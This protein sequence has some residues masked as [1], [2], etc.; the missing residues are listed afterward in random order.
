MADRGVTAQNIVPKPL[1]STSLVL[2]Y[3]FPSTPNTILTIK[4]VENIGCYLETKK[5]IF[6]ND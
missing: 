5:Y 4:S 6:N 1:P 3:A 2:A